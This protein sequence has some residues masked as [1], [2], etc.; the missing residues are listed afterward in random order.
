[1][2]E[3]IASQ[4]SFA[5]DDN[6]DEDFEKVEEQQGDGAGKGHD[7]VKWQ[8]WQICRMGAGEASTSSHL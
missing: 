8:L 2:V 5:N 6:D 1:M 7:D 3:M 4:A